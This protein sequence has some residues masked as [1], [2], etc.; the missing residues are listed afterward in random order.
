MDIVFLTN[1]GIRICE[2][3]KLEAVLDLP[4]DGNQLHVK[5]NNSWFGMLRVGGVENDKV[6]A[7]K[8]GTQ[9]HD[10]DPGGHMEHT[11]MFGHDNGD[12]SFGSCG[13]VLFRNPK[14]AAMGGGAGARREDMKMGGGKLFLGGAS[15]LKPDGESAELRNF[16]F[17]QRAPAEG[18]QPYDTRA[19]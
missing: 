8:R 13:V 12:P 4:K 10:K 2:A 17:H 1:G 3:N 5:S 7:E 15:F 19:C 14:L 6:E 16:L 18:G 11:K 9:N